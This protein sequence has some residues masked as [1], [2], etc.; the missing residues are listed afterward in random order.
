MKCGKCWGEGHVGTRCTAKVLNPAALPYWI[1]NKKRNTISEKA[2]ANHMEDILLKPCPLAAPSMPANRPTRLSSFIEK[3]LVTSELTGLGNSVVFDTHGKEL[4]FTMEDVAGFVTRTNL[5][6]K[7]EISIGMLSIG[8]FIITLPPGLAIETFI[9]ATSLSLWE[10]GF[11]FQQWSPLDGARLALPEFK[12]LLLLEGIPP[13]LHKEAFIGRACSTFGTYLGSVPQPETPMQ[14]LSQMTVAV[15]VERLE[16][17]P[18][19]LELNVGGCAT[20]LTVH[21]KNWIRSPLYS[22]GDFPKPLPK[23]S[24]PARQSRAQ[25]GDDGEMIHVSRRVL[26][27][28]C[29]DIDPQSLPEAVQMILNGTSDH[30][31]ITMADSE[32]MVSLMKINTGGASSGGMDDREADHGTHHDVHVDDSTPMVTQQ[33]SQTTQLPTSN[34]EQGDS[35]TGRPQR[36]QPPIQILRRSP[37]KDLEKAG[38]Q[39][40]RAAGPEQSQTGEQGGR[41]A[42][43][44]QIMNDDILEASKGK[45]ISTADGLHVS[46]QIAAQMMH[47]SAQPSKQKPP[48][49]KQKGVV[50][51]P[52]TAQ[53]K[54]GRLVNLQI[55]PRQTSFK[56]TNRPK[57]P[58]RKVSAQRAAISLN[59]EGFYEVAVQYDL[60]ADLG[61]GCGLKD[62]DVAQ[63]LTEDNIQRR[64][65]NPGHGFEQQGHEG[66]SIEFDTDEDPM[67]EEELE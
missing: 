33:M 34:P 15:A 9:N 16:R 64:D 43:R 24:K 66:P 56:H 44:R 32:E 30:R 62:T 63:A 35:A 23:F 36:I 26:R 8:R 2:P 45:N 46:N 37:P 27:D 55:T 25:N 4:N 52:G 57:Q 50:N 3:N 67:S 12:V 41:P 53:P 1:N 21:T 6:D 14:N 28:L 59:P 29:R 10:A 5:V 13:Y 11:S 58:K 31:Q 22:A 18:I 65:F 51:R 60:C 20:I 54:M 39:G 47:T 17:V 38:G 42:V 19:E 48:L 49:P 40:N 7:R 61:K